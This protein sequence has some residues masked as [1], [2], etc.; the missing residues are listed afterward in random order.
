MVR[1]LIVI[2]VAAVLT[3]ISFMSDLEE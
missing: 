1:M 3:A 2:L